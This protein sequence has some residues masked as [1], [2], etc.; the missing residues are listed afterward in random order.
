VR[1]VCARTFDFGMV[2]RNGLFMTAARRKYCQGKNQRKNIK[3]RTKC[4]HQYGFK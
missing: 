4:S 2:A 1:T 3:E